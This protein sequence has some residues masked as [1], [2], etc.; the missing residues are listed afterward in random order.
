MVVV[1]VV[2]GSVYL[3]LQVMVGLPQAKPS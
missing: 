3:K 1:V 2:V